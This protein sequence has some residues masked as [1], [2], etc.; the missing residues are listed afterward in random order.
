MAGRCLCGATSWQTDAEP[1][2][3][4]YCHCSMCRR[5]TGSPF[6][7]LVWYPRTSVRWGGKQPVA[8]RSSPI[9][10]R[11]HCGSCGTPLYLAYDSQP[12][13]GLTVGCMDDPDSVQPSHH[14]G[15]EARIRW[16]DIGASL[17]AESTQESW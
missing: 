12:M 1:N 15:T 4:H 11:A 2:S 9:A 5:W 17:P 3:V 13:L 16:V 8:F 6:A 14:Y 7:T 10:V